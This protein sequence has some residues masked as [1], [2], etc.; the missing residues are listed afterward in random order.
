VINEARVSRLALEIGKLGLE[1][2]LRFEEADPQFKA[3]VSLCKGLRDTCIALL[4]T[5]LNS[6]VSYQLVGRGEDH[7]FFFANYFRG[8]NVDDICTSFMD[9]VMRS[10]YLVKFREGKVKRILR[11]CGNIG[12]IRGRCG[13]ILEDP[14]STWGLLRDTLGLRGYE[15]TLVFAVKMAYYVSRG[16][17]G[18]K[19]VLPMDIP[20][21]VDV[22]VGILGLCSGIVELSIRD[23]REARI[24]A[25]K[26][27]NK[28]WRPIQHAW[29]RVASLS[30]VP[31]LHLDSLIWTLGGSLMRNNFNVPSTMKELSGMGIHEELV[32]ELAWKCATK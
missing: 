7:W 15:K 21:P 20:V 9:Y 28:Y 19:A 5:V 3:I 32:M 30:G 12:H 10:R 23:W 13:D 26:E 8:K 2:V 27:R 25:T 6:L 4:L 18:K 14:A 22:R 11:I 29:Q 17:L 24:K 31:P 1:G 16:C